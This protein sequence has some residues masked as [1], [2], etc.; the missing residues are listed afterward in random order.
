MSELEWGPIGPPG[1][2]NLYDADIRARRPLLHDVTFTVF[3]DGDD[4]VTTV[5]PAGARYQYVVLGFSM[6]R[7]QNLHLGTDDWDGTDITFTVYGGITA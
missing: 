2:A 5:M 4:V 6:R 7:D 3:L 1:P